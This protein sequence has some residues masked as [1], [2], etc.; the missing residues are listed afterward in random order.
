VNAQ[1]ALALANQKI[2]Q[3][4]Q[5]ADTR[6]DIIRKL[7]V[8]KAQLQILAD[9]QAALIGTKNDEIARLSAVLARCQ[10]HDYAD[11][12]LNDDDAGAL[13]GTLEEV[14]K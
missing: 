5:L 3:L 4:Q 12:L 2:D 13:A 8:E 7:D 9:T 6:M 10:A 1:Q 11:D 14:L